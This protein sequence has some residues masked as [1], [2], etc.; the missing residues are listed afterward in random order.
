MVI[1]RCGLFPFL[2][3]WLL[4]GAAISHAQ[5]LPSAQP[6][7][8]STTETSTTETSPT[9]TSPTET[10][11]T[12]GP[13][14]E[15]SYAESPP[16]Q[17]GFD[18]TANLEAFDKVWETVAATLW[19][20]ELIQQK[21]QPARDKY[22]PEVE[23][24][25]SIVK[26]RGIIQ[27]MIDEL[28]LSHFGII[29]SSSIDL[30]DSSEQSGD[31]TAGMEF[32]LAEAGIIVSKVDQQSSAAVAGVKPGWIVEKVGKLESAELLEKIGSAARG[33][34]RKETL[35]G[36]AVGELASGPAGEKKS[37]WFLD[38]N[39]KP[40]FLELELNPASGELAFFGQLPPIRVH[41]QV[42]TLPGG[43][44]YYW[45]NA[46]MDPA[47]V[48][49]EFRSIIR[50][51]NHDRGMI[52]DLRGNIG[53]IGAMTMGMASEFSDEQAS[54]G[55]MTMKGAELKFLVNQHPSPV[56]GP[57]AVLVDECSIS[58][59][60]IFAGGLQ[61]LGRARVFGRRTAG[62]ALPSIVIRLPN[63]DGFQ[64][65]MANYH[66]AS[67]KTLELNGVT[68]DEIIE[69]SRQALSTDPDPVLTRAVA[70]IREQME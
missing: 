57:V 27:A 70:W 8:S 2:A 6:G 55:V 38:E 12:N 63:G 48:M 56:Q 34:V 33:P 67:G 17:R 52:I 45:F 36:L 66:S 5:K 68:P 3:V 50:D 24:A 62:L 39:D 1:S 23:K 46:F 69:L 19:D 22:R 44:G 40:Q 60:E 4:L 7:P 42:R 14:A 18:L 26:V 61:D 10:S 25:D 21:W 11:T 47:R 35:V 43:I 53:G 58:S 13:G 30:I 29:Q 20:E 54:L 9:E 41:T 31:A 64:Y 59:A 28:E 51:P 15:S 16:P 37:F 32:R 49:P 65:A